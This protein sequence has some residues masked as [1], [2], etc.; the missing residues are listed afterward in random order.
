MFCFV[1]K[2]VKI[3]RLNRRI[4]NINDARVT[5]KTIIL[6]PHCWSP[7]NHKCLYTSIKT[8]INTTII[9]Q[10]LFYRHVLLCHWSLRRPEHKSGGWIMTL[11]RAWLMV[12]MKIHI[13]WSP[14]RVVLPIGLVTWF[15]DRLTQNLSICFLQQTQTK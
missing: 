4:F 7:E 11:K 9:E 3:T 5:T 14:S 15:S 6:L 13:L 12:R 10:Y 2:Y 8:W 1:T